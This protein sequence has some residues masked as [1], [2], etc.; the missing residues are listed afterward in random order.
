MCVHAG[1][2]TIVYGADDGDSGGGDGAQYTS[3]QFFFWL[4]L[5]ETICKY[6]MDFSLNIY[7]VKQKKNE[8][9]RN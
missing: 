4:L 6:W 3:I 8:L 9:N 1:Y 7:A 2:K 5:F